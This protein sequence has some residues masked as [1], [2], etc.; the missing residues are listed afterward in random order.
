MIQEVVV[1]E[2]FEEIE[3]AKR[4]WQ[5]HWDEIDEDISIAGL[6]SG[7]GDAT[8]PAEHAAE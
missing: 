8:R 4:L 3:R 2:Y 1:Q 5:K 6:L 7:R